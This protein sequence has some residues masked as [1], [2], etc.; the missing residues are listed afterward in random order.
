MGVGWGWGSGLLLTM[1]NLAREPA[2]T[3]KAILLLVV[4]NIWQDRNGHMGFNGSSGHLWESASRERE[5]YGRAFLVGPHAHMHVCSCSISP[6]TTTL[7]DPFHPYALWS[8][9]ESASWGGVFGRVRREG[10][11]G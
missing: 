1:L 6:H 10:A 4:V 3:W 7:L 5:G 8:L 2:R 9:W 11:E